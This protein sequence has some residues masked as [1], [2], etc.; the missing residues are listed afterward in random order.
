MTKS[1]YM[2]KIVIQSQK[3]AERRFQSG[4]RLL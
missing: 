1:E 2:K 3:A 4:D